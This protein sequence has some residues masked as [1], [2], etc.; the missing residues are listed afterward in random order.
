MYL[1]YLSCSL[2]KTLKLSLLK[3]APV[4]AR[5]FQDVFLENSVNIERINF[6]LGLYTQ[7]QILWSQKPIRT[8]DRA[9]PIRAGPPAL[10]K[11]V[12]FPP[13]FTL[14]EF[15]A[16]FALTQVPQPSSMKSVVASKTENCGKKTRAISI[17]VQATNCALLRFLPPNLYVLVNATII[18]M[19]FSDTL[20]T[21]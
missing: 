11:I 2:L 6:E 18:S 12:P 19:A 14:F 8:R 17:F 15:A 4:S 10:T 5:F 7:R 1:D 9:R 3:S 13:V 21:N 20:C 16:R